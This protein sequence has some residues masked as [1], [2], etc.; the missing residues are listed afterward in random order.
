MA[1]IRNRSRVSKRNS[2]RVSKRNRSRVQRKNRSRVQRKNRSRVQ[3]KNRSRVSKRNRSRVQRKNRSRRSVRRM[4]GGMNTRRME[5]EKAQQL[6]Q[7]EQLSLK[8]LEQLEQL[9]QEATQAE[10]P[11]EA[12]AEQEEF[13]KAAAERAAFEQRFCDGVDEQEECE[14]N[15]RLGNENP[16]AASSLQDLNPTYESFVNM[17]INSTGEVSFPSPQH[18]DNT[19]LQEALDL[20]ENQFIVNPSIH[21]SRL[22]G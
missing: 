21:I 11:Q 20:Q 19:G 10:Q 3:R 14:Y 12:A 22:Y 6:E 5:M 18:E 13:G 16:A 7:L 8:L 9:E 17:A 4:R 15:M 1:R 2:S